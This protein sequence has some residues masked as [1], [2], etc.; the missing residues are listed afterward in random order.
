MYK[1]W[2]GYC[3]LHAFVWTNTIYTVC[4]DKIWNSFHAL[5]WTNTTYVHSVCVISSELEYD[6]CDGVISLYTCG[7]EF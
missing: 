1:I 5:V 3:T 2:N 7:N 6:C 4:L